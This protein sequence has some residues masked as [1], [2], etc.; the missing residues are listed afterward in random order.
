MQ[1]V[2]T[3]AAYA[4]AAAAGSAWV[5]LNDSRLMVRFGPGSMHVLAQGGAGLKIK[6][7]GALVPGS[8]AVPYLLGTLT[9]GDQLPLSTFQPPVRRSKCREIDTTT[10]PL[11]HGVF[12]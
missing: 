10:P 4:E 12:Q 7:G 5:M 8:V 9:F 1:H 3:P 6:G 11:S 2:V